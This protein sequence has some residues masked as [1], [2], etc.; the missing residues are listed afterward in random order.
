MIDSIGL[1]IIYQGML[2][3]N[4]TVHQD[5]V[6]IANAKE[7]DHDEM[8]TAAKSLDSIMQVSD[9]TYWLLTLFNNKSFVRGMCLSFNFSNCI[10]FYNCICDIVLTCNLS[11]RLQYILLLTFSVGHCKAR[12]ITTCYN[13]C[14]FDRE[15]SAL[16]KI[17]L[18]IANLCIY[19]LL[20]KHM[21]S[22]GRSWLPVHHLLLYW[23]LR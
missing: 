22:S 9:L 7:F 11:P 12:I 6:T 21:M 18:T 16:K 19:S 2:I 13:I 4:N 14:C 5:K 17:H 8:M 3:F 1:D 23:S 15:V 10:H 20:T